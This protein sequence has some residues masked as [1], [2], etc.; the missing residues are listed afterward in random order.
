MRRCRRRRLHDDDGTT[1]RRD[2]AARRSLGLSAG[3][4]SSHKRRHL[5]MGVPTTSMATLRILLATAHLATVSSTFDC[6]RASGDRPTGLLTWG[7]VGPQASPDGT[8]G[9]AGKNAPPFGGEHFSWPL[10]RT[11]TS[12]GVYVDGDVEDP[13]DGASGDRTLGPLARVN[14][15]P[16]ASSPGGMSGSADGRD[17]LSTIA[18]DVGPR[19][20]RDDRPTSPQQDDEGGIEEM[21]CAPSIPHGLREPQRELSCAPPAPCLNARFLEPRKRQWPR[22]NDD[23]VDMGSNE[24]DSDIADPGNGASGNQPRV[25]LTGWTSA[26]RHPQA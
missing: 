6:D 21:P 16:Q 10:G 20:T 5:G 13:G 9:S 15:N 7:N 24:V 3:R 17:A 19:R 18:M 12:Q 26:R 4:S 8:N 2:D 23:V 1:M 22:L 14:V 11:E 25:R